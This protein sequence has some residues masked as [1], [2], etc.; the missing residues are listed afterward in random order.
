MDSRRGRIVVVGASIAGL[1][2][3][4]ELR[5]LGHEGQITLLGD[6]K[7]APY[8]RPP[9]SKA[10]LRG[11]AA[12]SDADLPA[13]AAGAAE[14]VPGARV[15][16]VST[17]LRRICLDDGETL[18]YDGLVIT[19]GA[20]ARTLADLGGVHDSRIRERVLRTADDCARLRDEFASRP[21]VVIVGAGVMGMEIASAA[22]RM[23]L[24]VTV[25]DQAPPM[26]AQCG[27]YLSQM[28]TAAAEGA[29]VK[30]VLDSGGARL[31]HRDGMTAVRLSDGRSIAGDLVVTA[32]GCLPNTEWLAG[33]GLADRGGLRVDSRCRVTPEIVAA[34]DVVAFPFGDRVRRTPLWSNAVEQ[35]RV[36]ASALLRG[37][38]CD[39]HRPMPYFWTEQFGL[40]VKV[41]GQLPVIGEPE[42]VKGSMADGKALLQW[43]QEGRPCAAAAVNY[44]IPVSRLHQLA[45]QSAAV[46]EEGSQ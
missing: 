8:A 36:A 29:G 27:P 6:E 20:R 41:C 31:V 10:I 45:A 14:F 23:S 46:Q 38:D 5:R 33:T 30:I 17:E 3:V 28:F 26:L 32:V 25:V 7:A 15:R 21:S 18:P 44:R 1:T 11:E 4:E 16:S 22:A 2:A 39:I 40:A 35:A 9:L 43:R 42:A 19:T 37:D 12:L 34:G 24:D 13:L